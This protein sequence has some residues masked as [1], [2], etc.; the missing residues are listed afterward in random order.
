MRANDGGRTIGEPEL[1]ANGRVELAFGS[2]LVRRA[3]LV[4][5]VVVVAQVASFERRRAAVAVGCVGT[6]EPLV[7]CL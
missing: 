6:L 1:I 5:V 7:V 2:A 4:V 3:H